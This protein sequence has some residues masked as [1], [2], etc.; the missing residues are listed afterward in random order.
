[1]GYQIGGLEGVGISFFVGYLVYLSQVFII[2]RRKYAFGFGT[3]FYKI[4]GVQFLLGIMCFISSRLIG[5][6]YI[7]I[8]GSFLVIIS[9]LYSVRE[10]NNRLNLIPLIKEKLKKSNRPT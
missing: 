7:Y 4:F 10:L 3:A 6:P 1:L 2:A 8:G 9:G 5:S